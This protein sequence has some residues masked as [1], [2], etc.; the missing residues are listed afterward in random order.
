VESATV[1]IIL[2]T[3]V[4]VS[5][6]RKGHTV[7]DILEQLKSTQGEVTFGVS[8]VAIAELVH[9]AYRSASAERQT[10][11]LA[12][13][14][15]LCED[16]PVYEVTLN[17]ARLAGRIDGQQESIGIRIAFEDLLIGC[18]A[19]ELGYSIATH[20]VRHFRQISGLNVVQL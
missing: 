13:I 10:A 16:V 4:L 18:T 2:D 11:R 12:F 3:S 9:G 19:L 17:V 5:G 1:G 15:R 14:E 7:A 6:E 8:V 20:N